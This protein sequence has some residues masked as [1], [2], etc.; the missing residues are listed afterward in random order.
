MQFHELLILIVYKK[1]NH[2]H[3]YIVVHLKYKNFMTKY[4]NLLNNII[5][6]FTYY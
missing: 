4:F 3:L 2:E 6:E 1:T 5:F